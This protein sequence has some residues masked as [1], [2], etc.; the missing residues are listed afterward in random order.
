MKYE[1]VIFHICLSLA[2]QQLM[3]KSTHGVNCVEPLFK[4]KLVSCLRTTPKLFLTCHLYYAEL[5]IIG[6]NDITLRLHRISDYWH[7]GKVLIS[8][9]IQNLVLASKFFNPATF[10]HIKVTKMGS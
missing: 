8:D 1:Y 2:L 6:L 3:I 4:L 10:G 7:H 9:K 5:P